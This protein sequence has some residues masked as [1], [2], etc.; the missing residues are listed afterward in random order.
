MIYKATTYCKKSYVFKSR[1]Q[2]A[3]R[4]GFHVTP[5]STTI[6]QRKQVDAQNQFLRRLA[7]GYTSNA[8]MNFVRLHRTDIEVYPYMEEPYHLDDT[9][10]SQYIE[11]EIITE[12]YLSSTPKLSTKDR[13]SMR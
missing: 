13:R 2:K 12:F 1:L 7:R 4:L 6:I 3:Q 10:V 11:G 8:K 5:T 9:S